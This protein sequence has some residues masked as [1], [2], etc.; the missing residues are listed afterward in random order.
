MKRDAFSYHMFAY[1]FVWNT[2]K[3]IWCGSRKEKNA[4]DTLINIFD[5][6]SKR[7]IW[8]R[9]QDNLFQR[10]D[11]MILNN[12]SKKK[13]YCAFQFFNDAGKNI[14]FDEEGNN[15][16]TTFQLKKGVIDSSEYVITVGNFVLRLEISQIYLKIFNTGVAVFYI[17]CVN[18][19]HR[20]LEEVKMINEYGR[21]MSLPFWPQHPDA[22]KKCAD[23]LSIVSR[24]KELL[25]DDFQEFVLQ[26][27][28]EENKVSLLYVST[29]IR[30][31]LSENGKGIRFRAKAPR[32]K[33]IQISPILDGKMYVSCCIS[34]LETARLFKQ[35][36]DTNDN[37]FSRDQMRNIAEL[38]NVDLEGKCSYQNEL[39]CRDYLNKHIQY[40][41]YGGEG[42]ILLGI[43]EQACIK[44]IEPQFR[45]AG[46]CDNQYEIDYHN[47]IYNQI[48]IIGIV[49]RMSIAN[50][51][52]RIAQITYGIG[53]KQKKM[54]NNLI[55]KIM[56][57]QERYIA[58]QSQFLL[59]EIT[60]QR[61]GTYI[62]NK[63]QQELYIH[64]E[65]ELLTERLNAIYELA[66][67]KQGY[68]FNKGALILSMA[69]MV[70]TV[71]S[72]IN[73]ADSL[74]RI[75]LESY[76]GL[77]VLAVEVLLSLGII[78]YILK[79]QYKK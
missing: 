32:E 15:L 66:N 4:V 77:P 2:G 73:E 56:E 5:S 9:M 33:E 25:C 34:D 78:G 36:F 58:F 18:Y 79:I 20:S 40:R 70:C 54:N 35:A 69:A 72:A 30:S 60:A 11:G 57:L 51:Q 24:G 53:T 14:V 45:D 22:Y 41:Q 52:Q 59:Y 21:R 62:Y 65:N 75:S 43:T 13:Y 55:F 71:F 38:I 1:P 26:T 67:M 46:H 17:E 16:V 63:I 3:A 12:D 6:S 28:Q 39:E 74:G 50:F 37:T 29:I 44:I 76:T 10:R 27:E 19:T 23:K 47:N 61:E 8:E 42:S 31:L 7:N 64:E 49:Q 68:G 48:I